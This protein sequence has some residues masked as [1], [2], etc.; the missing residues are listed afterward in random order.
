VSK[1][2]YAL[3]MQYLDRPTKGDIPSV[4]DAWVVDRDLKDPGRKVLDVRVLLTRDQ[5]SELYQMLREVL[6]TAEEG[7]LSPRTFINDIKTLAATASRDPE[8]LAGSTRSSGARNLADLG[9]ITEYIEDLPYTGDIMNVTLSDWRNWPAKRQLTF[10]QRLEEKVQ[11][12]RAVHDHTDLW[13][14]L[15]NGPIGGDSVFPVPLDMLP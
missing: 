6:E 9:F 5:L 7:M 15:D 2:G 8:R 1:L 3:R 13:V 11:Y 4:F 14:S 12:Y 10:I